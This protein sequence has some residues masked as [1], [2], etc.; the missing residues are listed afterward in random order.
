MVMPLVLLQNTALQI[1]NKEGNYESLQAGLIISCI[2][3]YIIALI[4]SKKSS[5]IIVYGWKDFALLAAPLVVIIFIVL[6]NMLYAEDNGKIIETNNILANIFFILPILATFAISIVSNT[7]YSN[8]PGSIFFILISIA[9]KIVVMIVMVVFVILVIGILG[10]Y[11]EKGR[12]KDARYKSGYRPGKS[13]IVLVAIA[14]A[15]LGFL[16]TFFI[17]SLVKFPNDENI[18]HED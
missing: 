8:M 17:K 18:A 9:G 3:I 16:A 7:R 1:L 13:N 4:F 10:G 15:I 6:Y 12:K 11:Q 5:C 2:I 14:I